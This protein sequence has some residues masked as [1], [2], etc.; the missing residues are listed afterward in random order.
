[1]GVEKEQIS[2]WFVRQQFLGKMELLQPGLISWSQMCSNDYTKHI[3]KE[4]SLNQGI[5]KLW[6]GTTRTA[7]SLW[8]KEC[9]RN[10]YFSSFLFNKMKLKLI[11]FA[12]SSNQHQSTPCVNLHA[13]FIKHFTYTSKQ[14]IANSKNTGAQISENAHFVQILVFIPKARYLILV[15]LKFDR[16]Q[17]MAL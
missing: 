9:N 2:C 10:G 1:M 13:T 12:T 16:E 17:V 3:K 8:Y 14:I 7:K 5:N 11:F 15:R 6:A 4:V